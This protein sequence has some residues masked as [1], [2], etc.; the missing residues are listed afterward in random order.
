M[1]CTGTDPIAC[2][3]G[4]QPGNYDVT[5]VLG[6]AAAGN[7][8]VQA[9]A[10]RAMLGATVTAAGA[11]QRFSFTVN[12]RQ[13]EG[14]PIQNVPA[15]TPGLDL[16]F[17]RQRGR[18]AAA[19]RHRLRAAPSP[20]V[21]YIAGDSTVCDQTDPDYGGWGQQLPPYFN[22]PVSVANYA[23]SGES[24]GSFLGSGSLFGAIKSR[25][26]ANDW[27]L[28]QF[29]HNDKDDD[30]GDVPRQHDQ[31]VTRVKAKGAFP[32]LMTPVARA[33]FSGNTVTAQHINNTGANL[34]AIIKQV[35]TEQNVPVLDMTARTVQWL[36]QLGPNGWQQY[37]ALGTDATHT[38]PAGAA[39]EAGFVVDLIKQANL[40]ALTSRHA[41]TPIPSPRE[42]GER[43]RERG[44]NQ[45]RPVS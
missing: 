7:T 30:R 22:Y 9:E 36:T 4:G 15:G 34:P 32:V 11:T 33:T 12:V 45:G 3:F 27:V 35:A 26:K 13:P 1:I 23:D 44:T 5:V 8:I 19:Q 20:F 28:I 42:S 10:L 25:L 24:S 43:V 18:A 17:L 41:L 31:L 14:E 6:G 37:H 39:V 40:T 21:I 29:G 2:H 38:N 16:Y